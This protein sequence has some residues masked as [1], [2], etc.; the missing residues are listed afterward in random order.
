[1]RCADCSWC[2]KELED[3]FPR[4]QYQGSDPAPCELEDN[5]DD[6]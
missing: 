3:D 6:D 4:C 1:M 5:Q 2:W